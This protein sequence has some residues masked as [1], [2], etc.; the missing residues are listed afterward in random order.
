MSPGSGIPWP[1]YLH[2]SPC[3]HGGDSPSGSWFRSSGAR[4]I[5]CTDWRPP[6]LRLY[7]RQSRA[8]TPGGAR[9]PATGPKSPQGPTRGWVGPSRP[10]AFPPS[11]RCQ[12]PWPGAAMLGARAWLCCSLL[13]PRAGRGLS[14]SRRYWQASGPLRRA[15]RRRGLRAGLPDSG[16][17]S[18]PGHPLLPDPT[19]PFQAAPATELRQESP[20]ALFPSSPLPSGCRASS[21]GLCSDITSRKPSLLPMMVQ[22]S[23]SNSTLGWPYCCRACHCLGRPCIATLPG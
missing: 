3:S 18:L 19:L 15:L 13:L 23:S 2:S 17:Q 12:V 4:P 22:R 10:P 16:P 8:P 11:P 20:P 7:G 1:W 9:R 14:V 6:K 21:L 5:L